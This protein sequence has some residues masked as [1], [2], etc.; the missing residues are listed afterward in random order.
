MSQQHGS[1]SR[2]TDLLHCMCCHTETEI[3]DETFYLILSQYSDT[4]LASSSTDPTA[5]GAWQ[6]S[7][8]R[9]NFKLL[10]WFE[11]IP[12]QAGIKP[13]VCVCGGGGGRGVA[14]GGVFGGEVG[15]GGGGGGGGGNLYVC[16]VRGGCLTAGLSKQ[17]QGWEPEEG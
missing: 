8:W 6:A 3:A 17:L 16:H 4:G 10:V 7:H 14:E 13:H 9:A 5:P 15:W 12:A 2:E 1:V 11:N